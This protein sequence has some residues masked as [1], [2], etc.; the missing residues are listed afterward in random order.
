LVFPRKTNRGLVPDELN[1]VWFQKELNPGS[2]QEQ[3]NPALLWFPE[4]PNP[5]V[6]RG[7][8]KPKFGLVSRWF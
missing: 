5:V 3:L 7:G 2:I 6:A 4:K 8:V 1:P